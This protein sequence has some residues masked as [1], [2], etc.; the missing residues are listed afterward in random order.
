VDQ[1]SPF[2][3]SLTSPRSKGL[4]KIA[5]TDVS[6]KRVLEAAARLKAMRILSPILV[7][8]TVEIQTYFQNWNLGKWDKNDCSP[9]FSAGEGMSYLEA[10][11]SKSKEPLNFKDSLIQG[12]ALLM[13]G[14]V[15]GL[16]A[17]SLRPTADVVK[18]V[19]HSVGPKPGTRFI[20]GHFWMESMEKKTADGGPFLL[21]DCAVMPEP[22]SHALAN[23]AVEAARA[24]RFFMK[25][26]PFVALLSFSTRGS[27][28]HPLVDKIREAV[29]HCRKLDPNLNVDGD[30][31]ADAAL[32]S[33]VAEIKNAG[34]SKVA[35]KA[36]VLIFPNLEAGNIA[37][38]LIQRFS[39][40]KIAGPLLWGLKKPVS[41]LSRGCT[42][43]EVVD[44]GAMVASMA[45]N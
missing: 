41:D 18:S 5:F 24:Y 14:K 44:T 6:D 22:S 12:I 21:A 11:N 40:V 28:H 10:L 37:Y 34:D 42:V 1:E 25:K 13:A 45:V 17:G 8:P 30:L 16:V 23:I 29:E 35:G 26:E 15:D 3:S 4:P 38:K 27:A 31:Q 33:V 7:G 20:S 39:K 19:L 43:E 9:D 2:W 36:N 32:D